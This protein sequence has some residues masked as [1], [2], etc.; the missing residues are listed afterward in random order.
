MWSGKGLKF[1]GDKG[2]HIPVQAWDSRTWRL[3]ATRPQ[4]DGP[5]SQPADNYHTSFSSWQLPTHLA[6]N[7]E[8][9]Q[10]SRAGL[11]VPGQSGAQHFGKRCMSCNFDD[12]PGRQ[13]GQ[14]CW[15]DRETSR[16]MK[17]HTLHLLISNFEIQTAEGRT[18]IEWWSL[19]HDVKRKVW[20]KCLLLQYHSLDT[21]RNE[22]YSLMKW[23]TTCW[24][25]SHGESC[26][27][28]YQEKGRQIWV[29]RFMHSNLRRE[30]KAWA[31]GENQSIQYLSLKIWGMLQWFR[32]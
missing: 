28:N 11:L 12:E 26:A 5:V 20:G 15:E 22:N 1:A 9:L 21:W 6:E 3:G 24:L 29:P 31:E 10:S 19:R 18:W 25:L 13:E 17:R 32:W 27:E 2:I 4:T 16:K 23:D 30:E 14:N 8:F 7:R